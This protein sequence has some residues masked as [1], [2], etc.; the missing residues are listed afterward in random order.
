MKRL[1]TLTLLALCL[2]F[3]ASAQKPVT[4]RDTV[5]THI[6]A[7]Q[8]SQFGKLQ[9]YTFTQTKHSALFA[10]D[11]VLHGILTFNGERSMRWQYTDPTDFT[12]V[13]N[14]DSI[15]TIT[16]GI[17]RP[18]SG[19]AGATTRNMTQT[20]MELSSG[21]GLANSKLFDAEI[22]EESSGY[23][24]TLTPKRRDM[25]HMMQQVLVFFNKK[26][27]QIRSVKIIEKSDSYTLIEFH[28]K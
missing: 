7:A 16:N 3:C 17:R 10:Q 26:N 21:D 20:M 12:L 1:F 6:V 2:A 13:V 28:A 23:T 25:R 11:A 14:G 4:D 27:L 22:T 24:V 15:Y 9:S 5:L 18:L 19:I 8:R